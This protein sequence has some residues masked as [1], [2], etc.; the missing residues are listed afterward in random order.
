VYRKISEAVDYGS[1]SKSYSY[2]YYDNGLKKTFTGPDG[3][4]Y[5]YTY[6][7]NNQLTGVQ[8]LGQGTIT[9]TAYDWNRPLDIVLPG[10]STKGYQYDPL[11]RIK[12]I[13]SK[14]PGQNEILNYQYAYDKVDNIR[15]KE[16]EHGLYDY[17]Y[18]DLYR[19]TTTDNPDFDDE[20]FTYDPVGNRLTAADTTGNWNYNQNNELG[21]YDDVS[22]VYDDNGNMIQKT[23]SGVVT[24]YIYNTEDRLTEVRDGSGGLIASYYYDPFGRRLWKEVSGIRTY[25]HYTDEG[26]TG[27]YDTTEIE[28][29]TYGYQPDS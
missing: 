3:I 16:T 27:E 28:I 14:D 4:I 25:F 22:F 10:G 12:Q 17:G 1:F 23:E 18:D 6:D 26:L 13:I 5:T 11:M 9:Y 21:E 15:S 20:S 24:N 7:A 2:T 19:L 8:I 29:K